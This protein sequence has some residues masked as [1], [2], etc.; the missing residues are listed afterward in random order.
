MDGT[1]FL[2]PVGSGSS[3]CVF[4]DGVLCRDFFRVSV[5]WWYACDTLLLNV[6]PMDIFRLFVLSSLNMT[7]FLHFIHV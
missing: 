5:M 1:C 6:L 3:V 7:C 2:I 4:L